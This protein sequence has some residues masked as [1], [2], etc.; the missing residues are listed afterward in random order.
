MSLQTILVLHAASTWAMAGLIWF[1]QLVHYP[2]FALADRETFDQFSDRHQSRTTWIVGPL[3]L[4]EA[5][6]ATALL[7]SN[8]LE[9]VWNVRIG[10]GLLLA[11]W[12]STALLQMPLHK[13]LTSGRD[14]VLIQKLVSTNTIRTLLWSLRALLA[15]LLLL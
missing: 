9:A 1:V 12:I 10:W 8:S 3:M 15:A 5:A 2:L 13:K 7:F 11:I 14:L 4:V 6:T